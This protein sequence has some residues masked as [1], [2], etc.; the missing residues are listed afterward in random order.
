MENLSNLEN[1]SYQLFEFA[2]AFFWIIKFAV[3]LGSPSP[4]PPAGPKR[5]VIRL[6][7][8]AVQ[9]V[10][11]TRTQPHIKHRVRVACNL[12]AYCV[13]RAFY[14]YLT[15]RLFGPILVNKKSKNEYKKSSPAATN[16]NGT[17]I[18]KTVFA[19][20]TCNLTGGP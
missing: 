4:Y 13:K 15:K 18:K 16:T 3:L 10:T 2:N 20:K 8:L 12:D 7:S 19:K 5:I 9:Q 6:I 14:P 1:N 17:G 11:D